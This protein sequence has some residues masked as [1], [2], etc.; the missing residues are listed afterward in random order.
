MHLEISNPMDYRVALYIRL[1]KED[2][3][4]QA[5]SESVTNQR[6]LLCDFAE[7]HKLD[8]FDVYIDDGYSGTTFDRPDFNRMIEDIEKKRVNM[9]ITKDLSR[10]GRDYIQTG[11][12]MERYFPEHQVRYISLLDGIDS[13]IEST[14][15]DITPFRAIM[16]DMYAKDISKKIKSVK[17]DKQRKGLFIGGKAVYG[18]KLSEEEKNKIVID[19]EAAAVVRKVFVM[20]AGGE[21]CRQIAEWLNAEQIPTPAVYAGLSVGRK[22]KYTHLWSPERVSD[23]LQNP[24][25][26][27]NMA[28]GKT[29]KISY[30]T[31][32]CI[33]LDRQ[34][35][36]VVENTHEPIVEKDVFEKVGVLIDTRKKTRARKYDYLL[37]G[38]IRCHECG[39]PLSVIN[40]PNA[41]GE[42]TLYFICRSYQRYA[43][44]RV[45]TCHSAKVDMVT[46]AVI[47]KVAAICKQYMNVCEL[48]KAAAVT[49]EQESHLDDS[50]VE[51]ARLSGKIEALTANLDRMYSDKLSGVL[52]EDDFVRMYSRTKEERAVLT[53]KLS[54][55][56][57]EQK[58]PKDQQ[59]QIKTLVD[60]FLKTKEQN[61]ELLVSLIEKVELTE[62]KE[63]HIHFRFHGMEPKNHLQ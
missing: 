55:L 8:V 47:K 23:M 1:S 58:T 49:V 5:E 4:E 45:C 10:L 33:R 35:W 31:K 19:E 20:A 57:T 38:L 14:A 18:Y 27:G 16:N 53:E 17:H 37:K 26:A 24:T 63:I 56:Q 40:R 9:V 28:Q 54:R 60:R 34:D 30:K 11:H 44:G 32:K 42:D 2:D 59:K 41:K 52:D 50:V 29:K 22:R 25:Y 15:N 3:N 51:T 46:E 13:G 7:K 12:Y 39:Y 6:S 43:K 21:S 36:K 61:K 48:E 62:D